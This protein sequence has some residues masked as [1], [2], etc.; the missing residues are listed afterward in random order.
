MSEIKQL[1]QLAQSALNKR[2]YPQAQQALIKILNQQ[3]D[4]Y[5]A[6]FLLGV[7]EA[8]FGQ[9]D[10]ATKLIEKAISL[11]QSTEYYAHLAKCYAMLG[12]TVN[13][14]SAVAKAEQMNITSALTFDT[15]G[16]ALSRLNEHKKAISYFQKAI[17]KNRIA[18]FYYNLGSSQTFCGLFDEARAS[19]EQAIKLEPLF[20]QAHSSLSHLGGVSQEYN[21]V[22]RLKQVY[23]KM[24]HADAKLHISHALAKE[25]ESLGE[26]EQ[27]FSYLKQAK[28]EKLRHID[29]HFDRD[30]SVFQQLKSMFSEPEFAV[31][32]NSYDNDQAIFITGMPRSGTTLVERVLTNSTGIKSAGELQDFG[33]T[34]K[35]LTKTKSRFILDKETLLESTKIDYRE[36]GSSYIECVEPLLE[37]GQRFVDKTPLNVLYAGHIIKSMPKAKILCVIRNPMDTIWGNYKQMFSLNDPYYQ[38]AFDQQSIALFYLEFVALAEFWQQLYPDNFKIIKYDE[39]VKQPE[40]IGKTLAGF[41]QVPWSQTLLDITTNESAVATAS[42]VQVRSAIN[43][44]SLGQWRKFETQLQPAYEIV[45]KAG[46]V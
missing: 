32:D 1:H 37:Q 2:Q 27:C 16:V 31:V 35:R 39:F 43:T 23:Q 12:D 42:S 40:V 18:A 17:D 44:K 25:L 34:L 13:T 41:C 15:L 19:Y 3:S 45:K 7:M 22:E 6:Y 9:Y 26:Y 24:P 10:K 36:L 21:H 8:E 46:L 20:Y 30:L 4:F 14:H 5:D 38:Y 11:H 33:L 29:Y 28:A